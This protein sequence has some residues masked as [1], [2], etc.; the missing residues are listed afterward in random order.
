M[1]NISRFIPEGPAPDR[2]I[3]VVN[4]YD[5]ALDRELWRWMPDDVSLA[6]ART[7]HHPL[8]VDEIMASAL[9][10]DAEIRSTARCLTA[11]E[12]EAVVFACTSGSFVNGIEGARRI[13]AAIAEEVGAPAVT[14]SEALLEALD[15][16]G[17]TRLAI[18]TPYVERLT[19]RLEDFLA[20][21]GRTVV[22]TAGLGL[23]RLIWHVPYATTAELVRRADRSDAQAVFVSCTN[24]PTFHII[25]A[26]EDEL[27]KPVLTANQVTAWAGLRRL[28]LPLVT[29]DQRLGSA[30][31]AAA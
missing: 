4:P 26:L 25:A 18:A 10:D 17:V 8:V 3:G 2:V 19:A 22:G 13:S 27:G 6:V 30:G 12:P 16:L 31:P 23:D 21:D 14:T 1:A 15:A 9:G 11:V 28:G 29:E 5:M 24:L 7:P 20:A